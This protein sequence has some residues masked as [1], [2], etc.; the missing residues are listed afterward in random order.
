MAPQRE[1]RGN[2]KAVK[3]EK[4]ERKKKTRAGMHECSIRN[5]EENKKR[6]SCRVWNRVDTQNVSLVQSTTHLTAVTL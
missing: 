3:D 5:G 1:N 2:E 4:K 6:F